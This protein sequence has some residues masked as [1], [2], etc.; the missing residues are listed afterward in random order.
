MDGFSVTSKANIL[1]RIYTV[2]CLLD[3]T[4][5]GRVQKYY[6]FVTIV[7]NLLKIWLPYCSFS[8]PQLT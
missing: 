5:L 8:F 7:A 3:K 4:L 6:D 2:L 1:V